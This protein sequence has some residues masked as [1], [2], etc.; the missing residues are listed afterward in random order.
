MSVPNGV[1]L[2]PGGV[3][4]VSEHC[5][6]ATPSA[7]MPRLDRGIQYAAARPLDHGR[8]GVLDRPV[9]PGDDTGG[10]GT[11]SKNP[12]QLSHFATLF[13]FSLSFGTTLERIAAE[14][15]TPGR[16]LLR[17]RNMSRESVFTRTRWSFGRP[18]KRRFD[19]G[20]LKIGDGAESNQN[21]GGVKWI[22]GSRAPKQKV[23]KQ[24]HAQ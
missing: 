3:G 2:G 12:A 11:A 4:H 19:G 6:G 18:H 10:V 7:V 1:G 21:R 15:L 22:P 17:S 23:R 14:S 8:R 9:K 20:F 16:V 13:P 5:G 24:P